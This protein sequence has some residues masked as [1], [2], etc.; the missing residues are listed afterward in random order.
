MASASVT[1]PST[2]GP[3]LASSTPPLRPQRDPFFGSQFD[4]V[5]EGSSLDPP[6]FVRTPPALDVPPVFQSIAELHGTPRSS[7]L[8]KKT[9][10]SPASNSD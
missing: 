10:P 2:L 8:N 1:V 3:A 9:P 4:P 6:P 7:F 5:S